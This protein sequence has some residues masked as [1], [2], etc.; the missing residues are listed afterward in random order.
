MRLLALSGPRLC[1]EEGGAQVCGGH[2]MRG[3]RGAVS[4]SFSSLRGW[5]GLLPREARADRRAPPGS[6]SPAGGRG[7]GSRLLARRASA[8]L[9]GVLPRQLRRG[10][11]PRLPVAPAPSCGCGDN[12]LAGLAPSRACP[13]GP[14]SRG[15]R[16]SVTVEGAQRRVGAGSPRGAV[17]GAQGEQL[18]GAEAAWCSERSEVAGSLTRAPGVAAAKWWPVGVRVR[19]PERW[20]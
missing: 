3:E 16:C 13:Q 15:A 5:P 6:P 12:T 14:P 7:E 9:P 18:L 1:L 17:V 4:G 20:A 19:R 2:P 11:F 10:L 8:L